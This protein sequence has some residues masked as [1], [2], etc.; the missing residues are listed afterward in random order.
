MLTAQ[1][2]KM[3]QKSLS[4]ERAAIEAYT[5]RAKKTGNK[6]LRAAF[7]HALGEEKTHAHLFRESLGR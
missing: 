1:E 7:R 3:A 2:T 5:S 4:E 6:R